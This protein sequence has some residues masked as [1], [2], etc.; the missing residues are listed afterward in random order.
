MLE[1]LSAEVLYSRGHWLWHRESWMLAAEKQASPAGLKQACSHRGKFLSLSSL[2]CQAGLNHLH[3][4]PGRERVAGL[5]WV[6]TYLLDRA[7]P[8]PLQVM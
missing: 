3:A 5:D 2:L 4:A 1:N 7:D 6:F 8:V